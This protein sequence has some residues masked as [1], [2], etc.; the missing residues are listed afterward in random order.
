MAYGPNL[1]AFLRQQG[2][3]AGKMLEGA[4]PGDLPVEAPTNF[5]FVLKSQNCKAAECQS[6]T[7]NSASRRRCD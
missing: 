2:V 5:E 1:L 3:M 6:S 4:T 7:F